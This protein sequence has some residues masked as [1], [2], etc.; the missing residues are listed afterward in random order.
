[1]EPMLDEFREIA[2]GLT[3]EEPRVP[4]VS[5]LT[6]EPADVTD[7]E[8]WVRH[9]R[10]SV[11]FMD[12]VRW[13]ESQGVTRFL[14]LGPEGVLSA[15][16]QQSFQTDALAVPA[17]RR[18]RPEPEALMTFLGEAWVSGAELDWPLGGHGVDLPSYA[19]QRRRYWLEPRAAGLDGSDHPL[20]GAA[21][22]LAGERGSV[23]TGRMSLQA[24]PWLADHAG[25]DTVLVPGTAFVD[26][27]LAAGAEVGCE[28][29]EELTLE[30]PLPLS[31]HGT[32]QLQVSVA[33]P[34]ETGRRDLAI[35]ARR[36]EGDA[37]WKRHASGGLAP[38]A[39]FDGAFDPAQWPPEGAEAIE[40]DDVYDRLA[41][42]GFVY[43][44]AFQ[45]LRAAWRRGEE[46]F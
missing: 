13:L 31:E 44:P 8:H 45:G 15:L 18:R 22:T 42:A 24:H 9:V 43:G 34:D 39:G 46:I 27:A 12:G 11:R 6:G 5:N 4:I 32:V 29:V 38:A 2:Q 25:L 41:D 28:A 23:L 19:F 14:E 3:F 21:V 26:L 16:A 7:P 30:A 20:L 35:Y 10:E 1:M 17:M 33:E 40:V 36:E 37:E